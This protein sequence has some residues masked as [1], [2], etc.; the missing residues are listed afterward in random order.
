M[1]QYTTDTF[2]NGQLKVKQESSGYRFSIDAVLLAHH[3]IGSP[4][5]KILDLGTGCGIIPLIMAFKNPD[6]SVH[7]VEVQP[8]LADLAALNV[9]E[10]HMQDRIRVYCLDMKS[11]RPDD[12]GG[13]VDLVVCNPPYRRKNSGRVNP[14]EQKAL[15]RHEI[16][17]TLGDVVGAAR[18]LLR[19]AGRFVTIYAVDR[20]T[21]LIAQMRKDRIE[22]KIMQV[23]YSAWNTDGKLI[24]IEGVKGGRPGLRIAPPLVIYDGDGNYTDQVNMMFK[25][26]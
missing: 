17:A 12:I 24:S 4:G 6:L 21:D 15:A 9:E 8:D 7:A 2:F 3:A 22:P 25:H 14:I 23:I 11:L 18:R 10:N 13:P 19:P 5:E 16:K 1:N 20:T 26:E